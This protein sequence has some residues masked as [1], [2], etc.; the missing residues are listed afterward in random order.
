MTWQRVLRAW[1]SSWLLWR[2]LCRLSSARQA[3]MKRLPISTIQ[4]LVDTEPSLAV[5]LTSEVRG[6]AVLFPA[7]G[8]RGP[9]LPLGVGLVCVTCSCSRCSRC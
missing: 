9:T 6:G 7:G 3:E 4:S 1:L 5:N 8:E 2:Q